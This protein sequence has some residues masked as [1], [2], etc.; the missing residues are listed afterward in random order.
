M[1]KT[2]IDNL[3]QIQATDP[4]NK[5]TANDWIELIQEKQ[6][7]VRNRKHPLVFIGDVG[8]GKTS[9]IGTLANLFLGGKIYQ[10]KELKQNSILSIGSGR[11]T[12]CEVQI[13]SSDDEKKEPLKLSIE[14]LSP[15]EMEREIAIYAEMEWHRH[16][17]DKKSSGKDDPE[18]SPIEIQ[19]AIRNMT[20]Y[21]E[22][23][24]HH[25]Q[26]GKRKRQ[27]VYPIK[28]AVSQFDSVEAF[29]KHLIEK[30]QIDKRIQTQ[31]QWGTST[32]GHMKALK[33]NFENINQGKEKTAMLPKRMTVNIPSSYLNKG[34]EFKQSLIDTRGING[35]VETR[36]DLYEYIKNPNALIVLCASFNDAPGE[37][38]RGLINQLKNNAL[39]DNVLNRCIMLLVDK[40][41]AE[42]VN[43]AD[44]E[45]KF[46]QD[47]KI[48]ECQ[49]SLE[50]SGLDTVFEDRM[51]AFDVLKDDIT[52]L[53]SLIQKSLKQLHEDANIEKSFLIKS[54]QQF[55]N[56]ISDKCRPQ[57]CKQIDDHIKEVMKQTPLPATPPLESPL[58]GIYHAINITQPASIVFASCRR[59]GKYYNLNLYAAVDSWASF[60]ATR[61][62][63]PLINNIENRL[64]DLENDQSLTGIKDHI[65]LRRVQFKKSQIIV[66][67]NY[68]KRLKDQIY[69]H[70]SGHNNLWIK[71]SNEWGRGPG[72]K[73]RVTQNL[74]DWESKQQKINAHEIIHTNEIPLLAEVLSPV[75]SYFRL[76]VQNLRALRQVEWAPDGL[77]I[78]I[79]ANGTGKST[80]LLTFKLLKIAYE[81]DLPEAITQV[82]GGSYRLK[83]RDIDESDPIEIGLEINEEIFWKLQIF[84]GNGKDY[85]T[86]EELKQKN[87]ILFSRDTQGNFAYNGVQIASSPK[88]GIRSLIDR[89]EYEPALR[90]LVLFIQSISVYHDPDLW[91]LRNHGSNTTESR[92][93]HSRSQNALTLLRQWQQELP[94]QYRFQFV[95]NG[96]K[97]AFPGIVQTLDFEEA[98]NTLIARTYPPDSELSIP[99]RNEAKGV[100]QF[101]VLLCNMASAEK[102]G[103][104][105]IDEPE[106]S[107]HPYALKVF[108]RLAQQWA[109]KYKVTIIL[110][111]HSPSILDELTGS[112]EKVYVMKTNVSKDTQ[113][114]RLDNLHDREWLEEF[115][116]GDLYEQGEIGSNEDEN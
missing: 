74:K 3:K 47:I 5:E 90:Q 109:R 36:D 30:S 60:Q 49:R 81:R 61:W 44:G 52:E 72:F 100:L 54:A 58:S 9:I 55:I 12:I 19:R 71:C 95:L 59:N 53:K 113:P 99:L 29:T 33:L 20:D 2:I 65:S 106:N 103:L 6:A 24:I 50:S 87:Q 10:K 62:L 104:I 82:F 64:N 111:T 57:L 116:Y 21:A 92:T 91:G 48:E 51:I 14:P 105:A 18:S 80:L 34:S 110:A 78:L 42:Q 27:T 83:S 26:D 84:S 1:E 43:G 68:A 45:R 93:L 94:N 28:K 115:E 4:Q 11:T 86:K 41:D 107:M 89:G 8:V 31:W 35:P 102:K 38:L 32:I 79:G 76:Y 66:V 13:C 16:Q 15:E 56:S 98:G 67:N 75:F 85:Q 77:N 63:S 40:D 46:G 73:M 17:P 22:Y 25:I 108:L 114:V 88:L 112:P 96:L 37:S 97:S 7:F 70:L 69:A 39:L 23:Q 101:L